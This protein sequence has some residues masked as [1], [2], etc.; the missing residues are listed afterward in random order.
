MKPVTPTTPSTVTPE[1]GALAPERVSLPDSYVPPVVAVLPVLARHDSQ[2]AA[3]AQRAGTSIE[4]AF[5]RAIDA[6][7]TILGY[8]TKLLGQG[9][10]RVPDGIATAHDHSYTILWDGKV[11]GAGY[12][13][14][15]D[16]RV[17]RDYVT[18]QS[19]EVKRRAYLRN[20]YYFIVS[21]AFADDY[22]DA[23]SSLKM[24]TD[25]N[26]VVLLEAAALVAMVDAK[27]RDPLRISLGP[28]GL[29]RLFS[30]SGVLTAD[31]VRS[32]FS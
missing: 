18:T 1:A 26:E 30:A 29:Q 21:S 22:D 32:F 17:I 10:G 12:S 3:A 13:M 15:T 11:R 2:M 31:K 28:D 4:R 20:L 6:A 25:V 16:D 9:K 14:G 5:E 23:I 19:R 27:L 7:F 24:E 8:E